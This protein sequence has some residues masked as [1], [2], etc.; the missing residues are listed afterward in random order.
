MAGIR[1]YGVYIPYNRLERSKIAEAWGGYPQKGAKAVANFDE[2]TVTMAVE[3]ARGCLARGVN[4]TVD[5]YYFASTTA[6]YAEKQAASLAAAALDLGAEAFTMD[7]AGSLRSGTSGI[8]AGLDALGGNRSS[9][10][11]VTASDMRLGAPNG[12]KEMSFGDGACA[13]L[14]SKDEVVAEIDDYYSMNHE[15]FDQ[16]RP[17][18][19]P[20]VLSW[21][22]R[23]VRE[24]GFTQVVVKAVKNAMKR[25]NISPSDISIPVLTAPKPAYLK[26]VAQKLG[27]DPKFAAMDPIY[28]RTG[29]TGCAHGF[30]LLCH[31][32]DRAE[33]GDRILWVNYG[34]GCDVMLL[35]VTDLIRS[36]KR[37]DVERLLASGSTTTYSK[38]L[39]W[40]KL[41]DTEPPMRPREEPVSA[42]ALYRDRQCGM[43]LQGSRCLECGT[44]HY[45]V[46]RICMKCRTKDRFDYYPFA[47]RSG[48]V[49]TFSHDL[50]GVTPDPPT[51]VAAVDFEGGGR[52]MVDITDRIPGEIAI[53]TEVE[54]TFRKFRRTNGIQVYW[55][56]SR[57][58]RKAPVK[59]EDQGGREG[60]K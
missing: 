44:V 56:K 2:D 38:Y 36:K 20:Y 32:L 6:P 35:T 37:G 25:F 51:T 55:W 30:L 41:L 16:F 14:L 23:F 45:P 59:G 12:A 28:S 22:E 42:P 49:V 40:R 8:C 10:A 39:R 1:D 53:G 26:G 60:A 54:M 58:L 24:K 5:R 4:N 52:M 50:L 13:L 46:Q 9:N 29:N 48:R 7:I 47:H 21:E 43:A 31:A 17:V 19:E 34:D 3:A 57:P 15:I 18:E 33:P 11:L 27:F